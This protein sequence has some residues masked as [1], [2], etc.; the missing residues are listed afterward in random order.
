MRGKMPRIHT[1]IV[2]AGSGTRFGGPLPKQFL[3]LCG[4]PVAIMTVQA[5]R[6]ALP[7]HFLFR[8]EDKPVLAVVSTTVGG[9]KTPRVE[10]TRA[11]CEHAGIRYMRFFCNGGF[12]NEP[13]YI[14]E[15]IKTALM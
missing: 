1:I 9:Y 3:P 6:D 10:K 15:R 7:V 4:V 5:L 8:K 2:A 11:A 14:C 12:P 13:E